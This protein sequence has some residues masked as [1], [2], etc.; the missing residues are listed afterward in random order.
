MDREA[1]VLSPAADSVLDEDERARI[2]A[3]MRAGRACLLL[4]RRHRRGGRAL[5]AL[6]VAPLSPF[7]SF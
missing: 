3:E 5:F 6:V 7:S 2:R 4:E 1:Q